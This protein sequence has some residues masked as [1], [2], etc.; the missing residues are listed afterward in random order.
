MGGKSPSIVDCCVAPLLDRMDDLGL[1]SLWN[2]HNN[3]NEW[4]S[5]FRQRPSWG[6]T[7]YAGARLSELHADLHQRKRELK[8]IVNC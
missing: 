2:D 8:D 6:K 3:V 4:L 1:R 7:F 5:R